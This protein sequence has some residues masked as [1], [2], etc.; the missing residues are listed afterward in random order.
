MV[1]GATGV[2][3]RLFD[4]LAAA[5]WAGC[6]AL[7]SLDVERIGPWGDPMVGRDRYVEMLA[8]PLK[9]GHGTTWD[10][11]QIVYAADGHSGFARV[12][13][14]LGPGQGMPFERF[15]Q[16]LAFTM[17]DQGLVCRVEVFWQTPW[18]PPP[19]ADASS[20]GDT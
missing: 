15:D 11:H 9:D 7:L 8:G 13:A 2:I 14:N 6:G 20:E 5:D 1:E 19:C 16:I 12:T 4:R 3:E 17:D 10:V 18:L